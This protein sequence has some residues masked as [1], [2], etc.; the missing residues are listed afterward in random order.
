MA[1]I[2][3]SD[4]DTFA[5]QAVSV[6]LGD[7]EVEGD[8]MIAEARTRAD[9]IIAKGRQERDLLVAGGAERGYKAGFTSGHSEGVAKGLESGEARALEATTAAVSALAEQWGLVLARFEEDRDRML[10]EARADVVRLASVFAER[11]TRRAVALDPSVVDRSLEA[12]LRRV[13]GA[14]ALTVS[15]HPDELERAGR[16]MPALLDRIGGSAHASVTADASLERGSCVARTAGGGEIDASIEAEID[17]MV[18]AVLPGE[19]R[20]DRVVD[21]SAP[22]ADGD[23]TQDDGQAGDAGADG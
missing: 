18:E 12:V 4:A 23:A 5:R 20:A 22:N 13:I 14:T 17:R 10:S 2:K 6:H 16:L 15:V 3:R 19:A 21:G 8:A 11:V 7:L 1:L 9:A